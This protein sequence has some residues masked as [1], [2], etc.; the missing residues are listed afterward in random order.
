[1]EATEIIL[2]FTPL[3]VFFATQAVK[4]ALGKVSGWVVVTII[5]PALSLIVA[6]VSGLVIGELNLFPQVGVGLL[7]VFI[8]ELYRQL[9]QAVDE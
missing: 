5:V 1:M 3:V 8:N 6:W 9:K 7:A 4:W 2:A